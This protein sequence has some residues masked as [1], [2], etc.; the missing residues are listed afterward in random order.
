MLSYEIKKQIMLHEEEI[1]SI[2]NEIVRLETILESEKA[3][4]SVHPGD[5][6]FIHSDNSSKKQ[7][8]IN[9][10]KE[11]YATRDIIKSVYVLESYCGSDKYNM[12]ETYNNDPYE[13]ENILNKKIDCTVDCNFRIISFGNNIENNQFLKYLVKEIKGDYVFIDELVYQEYGNEFSYNSLYMI[14]V[15]IIHIVD[16]DEA[17]DN[18]NNDEFVINVLSFI[19]DAKYYKPKYGVCRG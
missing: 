2:Q 17:D 19:N 8:I 6:I 10:I 5:N 3:I 15:P 14:Q 13:I 7:G 12:Y 11:K 16:V 4:H 18:L 1:K 9:Y